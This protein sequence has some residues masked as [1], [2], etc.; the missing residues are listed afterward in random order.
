MRQRQ[1]RDRLD[2][3]H[4]VTVLLYNL[5]K[6][7]VLLLKQAAI[8]ATVS[9]ETIEARNGLVECEVE[10]YHGC[11]LYNLPLLR[12]LAGRSNVN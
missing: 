5:R 9:G 2:R 6:K 4:G 1:N 7:T 12:S 3:G 11:L 10:N 8:I